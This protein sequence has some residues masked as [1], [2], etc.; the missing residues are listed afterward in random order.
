MFLHSFIV[1]IVYILCLTVDYD[2]RTV[3]SFGNGVKLKSHGIKF[4]LFKGSYKS[5][6]SMKIINQHIRSVPNDIKN[7]YEGASCYV[8]LNN[9]QSGSNIGNICRNCLAFNVSEVIIVGRKDFKQKMR[10][11][12]RGSKERLQFKHFVKIHDAENYLRVNKSCNTI[13][14]YQIISLIN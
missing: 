7:R 14:G 8:I 6:Y 5:K 13:L 4:L 2:K 9:L 12:D 3:Y 10:Q 11:A 1:F